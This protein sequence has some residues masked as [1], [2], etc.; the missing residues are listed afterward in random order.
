MKNK[1]NSTAKMRFACAIVFLV[2]TYAYVAYYQE[3]ILA[4]T[5]HVLSNGMTDYN[6]TIAPL[7]ITLVCALIQTGIYLLTRL[8]RRY[9][10]MTYL[11]SMLLLALLTSATNNVDTEYSLVGWVIALPLCLAIWGVGI[12]AARQLEPIEVEPHSNGWFSRYMWVNLLQL[13]AMMIIVLFVANHD[14]LFHQRMNM[15]RLMK[16]KQYDKALE[17]GGDYHETDS[18]LTMLRIACLHETGELG[19][20][21]FTYPLIGGSKAMMPDSIT[22]KSLMWKSPKWM[23]QPSAWMRQHHLKYRVPE[24]YQLCALLLDKRLD[25]FVTT[26]AS[27]KRLDSVKLPTHYKE[28]LVLYNHRRSKPLVEFQ[29]NVMDTD[30]QDYQTLK[31]KFANPVLRQ[32]AVRDTYGNTY[33]YYYD[34]CIK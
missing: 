21:L 30:F 16:K 19:D 1:R 2:F 22:V 8:K 31:N 18:S 11:P 6:Y 33:W 26:L 7:L 34:Y 28:A 23:Q 9:H 32:S 17:V 12:W 25:K 29:D 13:A 27:L 14:T 4:V 15:E 5:Q 3:N 10:A 20:R 24:D